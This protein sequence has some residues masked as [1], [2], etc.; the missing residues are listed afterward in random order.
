MEMTQAPRDFVVDLEHKLLVAAAKLESRRRTARRALVLAAALTAVLVGGTLVPLSGGEGGGLRPA[1]AIEGEAETVRIR[2]LGASAHP[3]AVQKELAEAGIAS[4]VEAIPASPSLVGTWVSVESSGNVEVADDG[5]LVLRRPV[6]TLR[7]TYGRPADPGEPYHVTTSAFAPGEA[8][9]CVELLGMPADEVARVL[10]ERGL[11]VSWRQH[12][13]ADSSGVGE[14]LV[15]DEPPP[16]V[17][18]D[19]SPHTA[20]EVIA[21][22]ADPTIADQFREPVDRTGCP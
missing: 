17:V 15:A 2:L 13:A 21:F 8:L 9:H 18:V 1:L 4:E 5:I 16:G 22:A 20:D 10:A 6:G 19:V 14:T 3:D 7:L 12:L 11:K